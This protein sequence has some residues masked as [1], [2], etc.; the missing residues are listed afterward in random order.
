MDIWFKWTGFSSIDSRCSRSCRVAEHLLVVH[1][2]KDVIFTRAV[3]VAC[4][5]LDEH[6]LLLHDLAVRALEFD[7][8]G[9]GPVRGA[10]AAIGTHSAKLGPVSL[11]GGAAGDLELHGLGYSRGTDA[12]LSFL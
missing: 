5:R 10:A 3:V 4:A 9:R 8:Q 11:G 6:H 12:L 1:G 2:L 7:G